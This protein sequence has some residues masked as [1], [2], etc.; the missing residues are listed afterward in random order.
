MHSVLKRMHS[1]KDYSLC[2]LFKLMGC[3]YT[4]HSYKNYLSSLLFK[5]ID[6]FCMEGHD[7]V[8]RSENVSKM[9]VGSMIPGIWDLEVGLK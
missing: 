8:L 2:L 3:F 1:Y 9:R 5:L 7:P 6:C 4:M